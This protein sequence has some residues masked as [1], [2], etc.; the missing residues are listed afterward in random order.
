MTGAHDHNHLCHIYFQI[1]HEMA[2]CQGTARPMEGDE[3]KVTLS[4]LA[5]LYI[6][7][8]SH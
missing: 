3:Y 4:Y 2:D 6:F 8:R 7:V 1:G 5:I